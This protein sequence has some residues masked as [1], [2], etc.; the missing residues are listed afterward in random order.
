MDKHRYFITGV[1]VLA[2]ALVYVFLVKVQKPGLDMRISLEKDTFLYGEDFDVK[3]ILVNLS[4]EV[5]S[6]LFF[7]EIFLDD[8]SL[9]IDN[10]RGVNYG[11]GHRHLVD[12]HPAIIY[13]YIKV[14]PGEQLTQYVNL[15]VRKGEGS[16]PFQRFSVGQYIF[17]G[18]CEKDSGK[19][20]FSNT[21][22]FNVVSPKGKDREAYKEYRAFEYLQNKPREGALT[23][24]TRVLL[25]DKAIEV[26]YK[27]PKSVYSGKLL[28]RSNTYR[29]SGKYK[30]DESYLKDIEFFIEN[31]PDSYFL[32]ELLYTIG[33]LFHQKLG[34]KEKAVEYLNSLRT[35][36]NNGRLNR[37]IDEHLVRDDGLR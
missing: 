19:Y 24:E 8:A 10:V 4:D 11:G 9:I 26:L 21:V 23:Q 22:S 17:R 29:Q 32:N 14:K 18:L 16:P 27:Y 25:V 34:G 20:I 35:K 33:S 5:D 3:F 2:V 12:V 31:N 37:L 1:I 36:F 30:Y 6:V 13:K 7:R 15:I 28:C